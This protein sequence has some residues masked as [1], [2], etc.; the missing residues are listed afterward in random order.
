MPNLQLGKSRQCP[1]DAVKRTVLC[2][3]KEPAALHDG[4]KNDSSICM[5]QVDCLSK[6]PPLEIGQ[7]KLLDATAGLS[8]RDGI[9]TARPLKVEHVP[10]PQKAEAGMFFDNERKTKIMHATSSGTAS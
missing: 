5:E 8:F 1:V 9:G 6:L 7:D 2:V 10:K 4:A 3:G